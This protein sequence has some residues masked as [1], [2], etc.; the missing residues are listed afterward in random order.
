MN[1]SYAQEFFKVRARAPHRQATIN[2]IQI[3]GLAIIII[4]RI[5]FRID[6]IMNLGR[7]FFFESRSVD[8]VIQSNCYYP[9]L[10]DDKCNFY[11]IFLFAHKSFVFLFLLL[12]LLLFS[13]N[14]PKRSMLCVCVK[15]YQSFVFKTKYS[16]QSKSIFICIFYK[17]NRKISSKK[18]KSL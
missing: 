14:F 8:Q 17:I 12:Y 10:Y 18:H 7:E 9:I 15:L 13:I 16:F 11:P 2:A 4:N 6:Q 5:G 3:D 1:F